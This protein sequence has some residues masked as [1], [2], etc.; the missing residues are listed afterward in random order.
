M[1]VVQLFLKKLVLFVLVV[2]STPQY[3]GVCIIIVL[4]LG[5]STLLY[6][7]SPATGCIKTSSS[8]LLGWGSDEVVV[9]AKQIL[10]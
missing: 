5:M 7:R 3:K 4:D 2:G 10:L 9:V 6:I 8:Y 1:H